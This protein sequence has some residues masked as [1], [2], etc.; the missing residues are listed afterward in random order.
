MKFKLKQSRFIFASM[1]VIGMVAEDGRRSKLTQVGIYERATI[2]R[3]A[4]TKADLRGELWSVMVLGMDKIR[5]SMALSIAGS[6]T[7]R[8][9]PWWSL[10][11]AKGA[12]AI[13]A[14]RWRRAQTEATGSDS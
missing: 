6:S 11:F 5:S 10:F 12:G 2:F 14:K 3:P 13:N 8:W 9:K 7:K 1:L 4:V